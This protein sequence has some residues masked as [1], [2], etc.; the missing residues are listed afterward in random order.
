MR[1]EAQA[2][3][4]EYPMDTTVAEAL[5]TLFI[6]NPNATI[7]DPFGSDGRALGIIANHLQIPTN[8]RYLAE[9]KA[10][11]VQT[12]LAS[13]I[14]HAV[15]CDSFY[16]LKATPNSMSLVIN[17]P[18][19]DWSNNG[20]PAEFEQGTREEYRAL[21]LV[22][23]KLELLTHGGLHIIVMPHDCLVREEVLQGIVAWHDDWT[24]F[25]YPE[26]VRHFNEV[27]VVGVKRR[28]LIRTKDEITERA[29]V[30][31]NDIQHA[32]ALTPRP[33][34][35]YT[36]PDHSGKSI[37]WRSRMS[38]V[39][40]ETHHAIVEK[41][42]VFASAAWTQPRTRMRQFVVQPLAPVNKEQAM[43]LAT[44]GKLNGRTVMIDGVPHLIKGITAMKPT[45]TKNVHED[46]GKRVTV[47]ETINV[48]NPMLSLYNIQTGHTTVYNGMSAVMEFVAQHT[49]AFLAMATSAAPAIY[50]AKQFPVV[51]RTILQSFTS[52]TGRKPRGQSKPG[53]VL[54]QEEAAAAAI[55]GLINPHPE[56]GKPLKGVVLA[57]EQRCG[58][59][60][61][62]LAIA[63]ALEAY[64][65]NGT[66]TISYRDN[67]GKRQ[68]H[69]FTVMIPAPRLVVGDKDLIAK[70]KQGKAAYPAWYATV[71]D[72]MPSDWII[73]VIESPGDLANFM[74]SATQQVKRPHIGFIPLSMYA[75]GSGWEAGTCNTT[76][77]ELFDRQSD[78]VFEWND[79]EQRLGKQRK[80]D[81]SSEEAFT[82]RD[83]DMNDVEQL[84]MGVS[85][86]TI[87]RDAM[88]R[89]PSNYTPRRKGGYVCPDC[90]RVQYDPKTEQPRIEAYTSMPE[91]VCQW[92]GSMMGGWCRSVNAKEV[93]AKRASSIWQTW[94]H[95]FAVNPDGSR[96]IP[97]GK[98][99]T[100]NPRLP[101][102]WLLKKRYKGRVALMIF[103]EVH[104]ARGE[105]TASSYS[106]FW[107]ADAA[108]HVI[109]LTGTVFGGKAKDVF[110]IY[111]SI[112]NPILR[113]LFKFEDRALFVRTFGIHKEIMTFTENIDGKGK[114]LGKAKAKR[115]TEEI[116]GLS[117]ALLEM[118]LTQTVM[119]QLTDMGFNLV[120][121]RERKVGLTMPWFVAKGYSATATVYQ[122][123][124]E[125][126]WFRAMGSATQLFLTYP[127]DPFRGLS[128]RYK[129]R[130]PLTKQVIEEHVYA[131]PVVE[132]QPLPHHEWL[133]EYIVSERQK[134]RRVV[135]FATHT[136]KNNIIPTTIDLVTHVAQERYGYA[137]N[138]VA[139]YSSRDSNGKGVSSGARDAWFASQAQQDVDV[140][141]TNPTCVDVG[142]SLLDYPSFVFLEPH[143][144]SFI[145][146]QAQM[147][148][149][150]PMQDKDCEVVFL[151]YTHTA[152]HAALQ[153]LSEKLA[154]MAALK[155]AIATAMMGIA[156]FSG[157]MSIYEQLAQVMANADETP[158]FIEFDH[159][160]VE[161][162]TAIDTAAEMMATAFDQPQLTPHL[163]VAIQESLFTL[164]T[165]IVQPKSK[166]A[167]TAQAIV[168][169]QY[170]MAI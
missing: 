85:A 87:R 144:S 46:A 96:M 137:I 74:R 120:P 65:A 130:D 95:S 117:I 129:E 84:P 38:S 37:T 5:A 123:W 33:E 121:L 164:T 98:R 79:L 109:Y 3:A 71:L 48:P 72:M 155:G 99:P 11:N 62:S 111:W 27:I 67:Q 28:Y 168:Q 112:H 19:F 7:S 4:G 113:K 35:L 122:Q 114:L 153:I 158:A 41:G 21:H 125:K 141:F 170:A 6:A 154:A 116:P 166:Y 52:K 78:G 16:E 157:A 8:N 133:A 132:Y 25:T 73:G 22:L 126:K 56:T 29:A 20:G 135:V 68:P 162:H 102:S 165:S 110:N 105:D 90:G 13:G 59:T 17:N 14:D 55:A 145:V 30:L 75:L 149:W 103:D 124:L 24:V 49:D 61:T 91:A 140:V 77:L 151:Y 32:Q 64:Y 101:I 43:M 12:A 86:R 150:G 167:R 58:K 134:G 26:P 119:R 23:R 92:C 9:L 143:Y 136:N 88:L 93:G 31:L 53:L 139:L 100:S 70:A 146:S 2:I 148:A 50:Q 106:L 15:A 108:R 127:Y 82:D 81:D 10:H 1:L 45:V 66:K 147:R 47:K 131:P 94:Q 156:E 163:A 80:T 57:M 40:L 104:K 142:I 18:P 107:G 161:L 39:S 169:E 160:V 152:S 54:S 69:A 159:Q 76:H 44:A 128:M 118:V 36:L 60:P 34:P 63:K 89:N 51:L 42:G 138:A 115:D 97:W 83:D